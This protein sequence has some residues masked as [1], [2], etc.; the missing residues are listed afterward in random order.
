MRVR[1]RMRVRV[2][3][4]YHT[5]VLGDVAAGDDHDEVMVENDHLSGRSNGSKKS[6]NQKIC[7]DSVELVPM[8]LMEDSILPEKEE[9]QIELQKDE[10]GLGITVAGYIC[11]KGKSEFDP[12]CCS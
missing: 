1:A 9:Y 12:N 3:V 8:N 4:A 10:K 11:E 7:G 2:R 5:C 6:G